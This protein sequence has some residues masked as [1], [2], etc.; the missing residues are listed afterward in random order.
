MA[1]PPLMRVAFLASVFCSVP[2]TWNVGSRLARAFLWLS[3][4]PLVVR[5]LENLPAGPAVIAPNHTSYMDGVVLM[6]VLESGGFPLVG[7]SGVPGDFFSSPPPRGR[8]V[9]VFVG[10]LG[11][12]KPAAQRSAGG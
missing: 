1:F 10:V 3:G 8:G 12:E 9:R 11:A 4:I 2:V 5:G 7:Q 6:A